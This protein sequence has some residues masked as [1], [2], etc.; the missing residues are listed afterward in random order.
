M[1]LLYFLLM[2]QVLMTFL[3]IIG[4]TYGKGNLLSA[5]HFVIV[6]CV[7]GLLN[8]FG[9]Y[10]IDLEKNEEM[11][12]ICFS[13]FW[14]TMIGIV[15]YSYMFRP[16]ILKDFAAS[17][18]PLTKEE[19]EYELWNASTSIRLS[20]CFVIGSGLMFF[21]IACNILTYK[22]NHGA[23]RMLMVFTLVWCSYIVK[24][25]IFMYDR[26]IKNPNLQKIKSM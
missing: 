16:W 4:A 17:S 19:K 15:L 13:L 10:N 2:F 20:L 26:F 8:M 23:G 24:N 18:Y 11:N 6:Q 12:E 14:P 25:L 21:L 22:I 3:I 5:R 1:M 9:M 7:I